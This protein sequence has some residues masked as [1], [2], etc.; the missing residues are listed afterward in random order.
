MNNTTKLPEIFLAYQSSGF[1]FAIFLPAF[2][3]GLIS[4]FGISMN[5]SVCYIVVKYWGKYTA[6]KSKT[7]IL[8]AINSFCEVLHQIGHLFFLIFTIKGSN[9]VPAI[10]AFKYQAIPIFGFFASIFMFA[11]LSLDRVFAIAFPIL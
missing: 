6:M 1:Q 3:M 8:L 9:F 10:V 11:S 2:C 5:S 7:S 4:L